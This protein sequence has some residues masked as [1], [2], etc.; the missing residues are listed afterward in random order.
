MAYL[1]GWREVFRVSYN[2]HSPSLHYL[3]DK[4]AMERNILGG[5]ERLVSQQ[6]IRQV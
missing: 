3:D 2:G 1:E 6:F 5:N 4:G